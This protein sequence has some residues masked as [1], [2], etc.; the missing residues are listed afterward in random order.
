M[1]EQI[2]GLTRLQAGLS[3]LQALPPLFRKEVLLF[4]YPLTPLL[5]SLWKML[6]K[7][8]TILFQNSATRF[9]PN[10]VRGGYLQR[11]AG[12]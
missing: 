8:K 10:S 5:K 1:G 7:L 2:S 4:S 12:V 6:H 11:G 3:L 9:I